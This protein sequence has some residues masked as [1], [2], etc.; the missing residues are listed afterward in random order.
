MDTENQRVPRVVEGIEYRGNVGRRIRIVNLPPR[1]GWTNDSTVKQ[2]SHMD[3]EFRW[4][5]VG[6]HAND[7]GG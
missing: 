7:S 3:D 4:S 2:L 1:F 6:M 5:S